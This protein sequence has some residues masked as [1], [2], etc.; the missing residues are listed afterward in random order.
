M[1][2][3]AQA[4]SQ[5]LIACKILNAKGLVEGFGHVSCRLPGE[6]I[7]ITPRKG[8]ALVGEEDLL[9]TDL[10]GNQ[11]GGGSHPPLELPMHTQ[12]YRRHSGVG[13]ICRTH[14]PWATVF[15]VAGVPIRAVH[16][17]GCSLG[18]EVPV[19][20]KLD[21]IATPEL[22]AEVAAFLGEREAILLRGNGT[23][24]VGES[25]PQA[26]AKAIFLEES[27]LLQYRAQA[28]PQATWPIFLSEEEVRR[29][30][31]SDLPHEPIRAWEYYAATLAS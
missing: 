28:L 9:I 23:I 22:G 1:D 6:R 16:G 5:V 7:L 17:F 30:R 20:P 24:V 14:S 2:P 12:I 25:I 19:F 31:L 21:L 13:A 8:L 11:L 4:R 29:R 3:D 27:A 26:V 15:G 10:E 18:P